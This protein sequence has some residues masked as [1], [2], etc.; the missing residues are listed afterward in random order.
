VKVLNVALGDMNGTVSFHEA[1]DSTMGSLMTNGY[2]GQRGKVIQVKCRTLDS[3]VEEL[4]IKPDF[5]KIDVEG[6]THLVLNGASRVLREF[7][8][9]IVLEANLDD[10]SAL[11]TQV[12]SKHRYEI[13]HITMNGPEKRSEVSPVKDL[14]NWLCVPSLL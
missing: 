13:Y 2:K 10:P 7:R 6:F 5:V 9:R 1:E 3:V 8:P 12:L 4:N 14:S 11:I